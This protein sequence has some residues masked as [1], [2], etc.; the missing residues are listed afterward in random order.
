M[1]KRAGMGVAMVSVIQN[2]IKNPRRHPVDQSRA[3]RKLPLS[4]I[5]RH[6][7]EPTTIGEAAGITTLITHTKAQTKTKTSFRSNQMPTIQPSNIGL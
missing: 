6:L 2:L 1:G 4:C 3:A 5:E 7:R